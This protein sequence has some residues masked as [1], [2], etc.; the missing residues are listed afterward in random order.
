[1]RNPRFEESTPHNP[2][3]THSL[4]THFW[5]DWNN[6][7]RRPASPRSL[8]TSSHILYGLIKKVYFWKIPLLDFTLAGLLGR[9]PDYVKVAHRTPRERAI[10]KSVI[11]RETHQTLTAR[12]HSVRVLTACT[13]VNRSGTVRALVRTGLIKIFKRKR[14]KNKK[15]IKSSLF[16]INSKENTYTVLV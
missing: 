9:V 16:L 4:R 6:S 1:M 12:F 2:S 11:S 3:H 8:H 10:R 5:K 13:I 15:K 14:K 7:N